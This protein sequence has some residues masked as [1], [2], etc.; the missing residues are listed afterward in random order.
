MFDKIINKISINYARCFSVIIIFFIFCLVCGFINKYSVLIVH[1]YIYPWFNLGWRI[2]SQVYEML[3]NNILPVFFNANPND[4]RSGFAF[5][6]MLL[7]F[8]YI[9]ICYLF[10]KG[11][12]IY[13]DRKEKIIEKKEFPLIFILSFLLLFTQKINYSDKYT[14]IF[15]LNDIATSAE[16]FFSFVP[17]LIFLYV[18]YDIFLRGYKPKNI[19]LS[20][21]YVI[22]AFVTCF[23]NELTN[24]SVAGFSLFLMFFLFLFNRE[25]LYNKTS[26]I[27]LLPFFGGFIYYYFISGNIT[28]N[29]SFYDYTLM[30]GLINF[31]INFKS[32]MLAYIDTMFISKWVFYTIIISLGVCL[33]KFKLKNAN[34]VLIFCSSV[35]LSYL[36]AN[37][38]SVFVCS[39]E[40][41]TEYIFQR[42]FW[43][44]FY[45]NILELCCL[46]LFGCLYQKEDIR[47]RL[48][49]VLTGIILIFLYFAGNYYI[50]REKILFD[51]K[52]LIYRVDKINL[53]FDTFGESTIMPE[54][55][56]D[57]AP[58]KHSSV[59]PLNFTFN[60]E[61]RLEKDKYIN[62]EYMHY[63]NYFNKI[64]DRNY[65]GVIYKDDKTA[66]KEI[67]Q[68]LF[69]LDD[70][71][72]TDE[73]LRRQG[74]SF[75]NIYKKY[76]GKKLTLSDIYDIERKK[77]KSD[78]LDK[79]KAY[80]YFNN[81]DYNSA[82]EFYKIY[83]KTNPDDID[84]LL[85]IAQIYR[86]QKKYKDAEKIYKRLIL[87]DFNN[88]LFSYKL[89]EL[90]YYDMSDYDKAVE[91]CNKII[92]ID[93]DLNVSYRNM[94]VI[95][96]LVKNRDMQK[97]N[98]YISK[99]KKISSGSVSQWESDKKFDGLTKYDIEYPS[100]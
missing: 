61:E 11:F 57:Y 62:S 41:D 5:G 9:V 44:L 49:I 87:K 92:E 18:V 59:F 63:G 45:V 47:R 46:C 78:V 27:L 98:E 8:L 95:L 4:F 83:L 85:N 17:Y 23:Y 89:L 55:Y 37:F 43:D 13:S 33:Y 21:L 75:K 100:F 68:R 82:L 42:P 73:D 64:Y 79:A 16:Y 97:I 90:Y 70:K 81:K 20:V 1:G 54:S 3:L 40:S 35:L 14:M 91:I 34:N 88:L 12:F 22:L 84:A 25:K 48:H 51:I 53:V 10:S 96:N 58:I 74:I 28:N 77:G 72:E 69:L 66:L 38:A 50:A 99:A 29:I 26:L 30:D 19:L 60:W 71:M 24:I 80:I 39:M 86:L 65:K 94:A 52:T 76:K 56:L 32:I 31:K 67:E 2:A 15:R 36:A 93:P 6:S 7:S